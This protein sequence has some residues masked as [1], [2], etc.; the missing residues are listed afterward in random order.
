MPQPLSDDFLQKLYPKFKQLESWNEWKGEFLSVLQQVQG[1][2]VEQLVLPEQQETR[3]TCWKSNPN[4][5][6][7]PSWP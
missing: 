3:W 7:R 1:W 2:T 6:A 5:E 4:R